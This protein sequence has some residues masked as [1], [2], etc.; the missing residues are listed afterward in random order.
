[1]NRF[2]DFARTLPACLEQVQRVSISG[3]APASFV[4]SVWG[5]FSVVVGSLEL[6]AGRALMLGS[7][8]NR[9]IAATHL[10]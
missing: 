10:L 1:M 2:A 6:A 9:M 7:R 4:A 3:A 8:T 5:I